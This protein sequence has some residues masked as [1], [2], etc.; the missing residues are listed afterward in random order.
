MTFVELAGTLPN[1]FHDAELSS[2]EMDYAA[3]ILR[4][5][6]EVWIGSMD[7]P[8]PRRERYRLATVTCRDVAYFVVEPPDASCP[9]SATPGGISIDTGEGSPGKYR[10]TLPDAPEGT[11]PIWMFVMDYN[12]FIFFAAGDSSLEWT[13]ED[14]FY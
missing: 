9:G 1:R 5:N 11:T 4:L 3:R 10:P 2:F 6:L 14:R 8:P 13:G 7:E 12:S